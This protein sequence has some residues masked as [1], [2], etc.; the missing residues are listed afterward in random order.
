MLMTQHTGVAARNVERLFGA[1]GRALFDA[2]LLWLTYLGLEPYIRRFSPGSLIGWTRLLTG[3]WRDPQVA[4]E[5]LIGVC[6]GLGMTL[7]YAVHNLIPP[8]LGQPEPMPMMPADAQV[9]MGARMAIGRILSQLG[10]AMS[11]GMLAVAG[12]VTVLILVKRKWVAQILSSLVFVWVVIQ[13]MFPAGTPI[14][15]V[16]I[17]LGIIGLWTGV[18]LYAGLLSTIAALAT[19]FMLLRAPLTFDLGSWRGTPSLTYLLVLG[20][21]ALASAYLAWRPAAASGR[22]APQS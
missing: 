14:L 6:A 7:F 13:G 20:G 10:N 21:A 19:H 16:L 15:D 18:I 1:I 4:T 9:M 2:G 11:Q 12:V 3:R 22:Q 8:L 17:G 5:V